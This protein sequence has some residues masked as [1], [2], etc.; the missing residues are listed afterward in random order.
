MSK[1]V[2]I[3]IVSLLSLFSTCISQNQDSLAIR[4]IFTEALTDN[5]A[6]KNLEYLCTRIGGRLCGSPQAAKAVEWAKH[7]LD[8]MDLDTVYLQETSVRHWVRG[9]KE[10][11]IV[12][13]NKASAYNLQACALGG[14]IGTG[15]KGLSANVIEVKEFDDLEK[16]GKQNIS[17]KIVFFNHPADPVFYTTF[18]AYGG[19]AGFRVRGAVQAARYG[20]IAAVVRSAT[21]AHDDFPHTGI[22]HY[23][24]TVQKI[25]AIAISTNDADKLSNG[26]KNDPN[27]SLYIR[28]TCKEMPE[29]ISYNVI[30]EIRGTEYP[31]QIIAFGGHIDSWELGQGA[32]DDG[33]GVIQSIEVLRLFKALHIRPK[34]T[35]RA[36][37]FMDEEMD[38][39][40]AKRYTETVQQMIYSRNSILDQF[41]GDSLVKNSKFR[42]PAE[43]IGNHIAAIEADRGGFTPLG[44]SIDASD[45]QL[46]KIQNWKNLLL[47]YGL[48]YLEKGGSGV[49]VSGLKKFGVPVIG[50]VTDSQRYFDYHHAASDTF[51][52][53]HPR[54]LQLGSASM[55][56][57]V[58]LIDIYGL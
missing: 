23:A 34:H 10:I 49:D 19:A 36:I 51:D 54:E 1:L 39:R 26:L 45:T 53:V 35:L 31:D 6:Y 17:G 56:A 22:M 32:H 46:K 4:K 13:R 30:G 29:V 48:Y 28:L 24:D 15:E 41:K 7:V 27:L 9:E 8:G 58:Y 43:Y 16:L 5:T 2:L 20:A 33:T 21:L 40:G 18:N 42:Q 44:F 47:P 37:A 55:A 25:P 50:L 57:L 38:Q 12:N 14:S 3:T 52:K 11:A